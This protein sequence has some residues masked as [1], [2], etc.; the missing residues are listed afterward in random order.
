M[1]NCLDESTGSKQVYTDMN[2]YYWGPCFIHFN[3]LIDENL[4]QLKIDV[5]DWIRCKVSYKNIQDLE[6]AYKRL[7][8]EY[9]GKIFR[10]KNRINGQT[11]DILLNM[12]FQS[13]YTEVQLALSYDTSA[14]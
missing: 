5:Y 10:V 6:N 11:R 12:K 14:Y 13:E 9:G 2:H 7:H 1:D 4:N 8:H 3:K